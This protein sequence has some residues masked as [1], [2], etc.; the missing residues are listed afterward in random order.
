MHRREGIRQTTVVYTYAR[1]PEPCLVIALYNK[2]GRI[3][4]YKAE[5]P[6]LKRYLI[7]YKA[8]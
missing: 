2:D 3:P 4:Y 8:Y 6:L 1:P 7:K 5:I